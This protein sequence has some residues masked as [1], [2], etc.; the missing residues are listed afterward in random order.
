VAKALSLPPVR[1]LALIACLG[2]AACAS[3]SPGAPPDGAAVR[4]LFRSGASSY[5][6]A[7]GVHAS[8]AGWY[9]PAQ[10]PQ[11]SK[12]GAVGWQP[13]ARKGR[14]GAWFSRVLARRRPAEPPM[15][16]A[17]ISASAGLPIP[18]VVTVTNAQ[19]YA[20]VRVRVEQSARLGPALISLPPDLAP[21]LGLEPGRAAQVWV[22]YAEPV[23][24]YR[25]RPDTRQAARPRL[26]T[27]TLLAAGP[28]RQAPAA[29]SPAATQHAAPA[30]VLRV[31]QA[32]PPVSEP[33]PVRVQAAAFS[34]HGNAQRAMVKLARFG[35]V[36]IEPTD[37]SGQVL[38][39]VVVR[40]VDPAQG[41][42][43]REA[44]AAQGFPDARLLR[45][46]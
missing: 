14:V 18:S 43:L 2:V 40:G 19:T 20:T 35:I 9:S 37:R 33:G 38:Y 4:G 8:R 32:S 3:R 26:P 28:S 45:G 39:R 6:T 5:S 31:P 17:V 24:A 34:N 23:V 11:F 16:R 21:Q 29:P 1:A 13:A 42:G 36:G 7:G 22:R 10:A 25:Q 27:E 12:M 44:I 30:S 41:D 15:P 46:S